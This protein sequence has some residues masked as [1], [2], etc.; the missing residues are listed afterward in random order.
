[1]GALFLALDPAIDRLV[2]LKLLR[3]D[4]EETR[5]R[6]LREARS[7]GRLQHPHIV[8]VY[9]VGEHQGQPFIAMEYVKGETL[10]EVIGRRAPLSIVGKLVLMEDLCAGLDY[11]HNEG[12]VHRD[13]KP[14]NLRWSRRGPTGSR[15]LTSELPG[16]PVIP[17]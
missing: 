6:F 3:V 9:D 12:L 5:A 7:A 8:T 15:F 2:A 4:N 16:A 14:A 1:M 10:G 13:I 17:G 11:A